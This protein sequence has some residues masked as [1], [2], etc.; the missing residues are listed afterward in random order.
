MVSLMQIDFYQ[1]TQREKSQPLQFLK[2]VKDF[3]KIVWDSGSGIKQG[4]I[5]DTASEI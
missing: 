5:L 3:D 1:N 4:W 2:G